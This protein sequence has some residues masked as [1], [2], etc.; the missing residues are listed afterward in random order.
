MQATRVAQQLE[1]V[2]GKVACRLTFYA[3]SLAVIALYWSGLAGPFILDDAYNLKPLEWWLRGGATSREVI[4]GN[5]SG[6]LGRPVSM[7]SFLLTVATGGMHPFP[8]KFGNLLIHIGCAAL[9]WQLARRLFTL[10]H[11]LNPHAEWLGLAVGVL[12]LLHPIHVSTVL[13]AVQRM[14]QLSTFFT[15]LA[16]LAYLAGRRSLEARNIGGA[17]RWL[18]LAFPMA[19]A[20]GMLSKENAAVAPALCLLV[21]L[22]YF[23]GALRSDR[24]LQAFFGVFL[25]VPV[26]LGMALLAGAPEK[27]LALYDTRDFTLAER[28]LSQPRA[29]MAYLGLLFWPRGG[30]MGVF[31]DDFHASTGVLQPAGTLLSILAL[32]GLTALAVAYRH[33]APSVFLGWLFFLVAHGVE[34]SFLPLE[35]Y[36]E[37]RNYLPAA[38]LVLAASGLAFLL[39]RSVR[40]RWRVP[41]TVF[42]VAS[43]AGVSLLAW[44]TSGQVHTWRSED[45]LATQAL[46]HRPASLRAKLLKT[47]IALRAA[48]FPEAKFWAMELAT[49][50]VKRHR[51][52]G[53]VHAMTIDCMAGTSANLQYLESAVAAAM[54][55]IQL[56]DASS[57]RPL[58]EALKNGNC[59]G[60][61]TPRLLADAITRIINKAQAQPD[62]SRPKWMLRTTAATLYARAGAWELA[63]RQAEIAWQPAVDPAVGALLVRIYVRLGDKALAEETL[64]EVA[65]RVRPY[66]VAGNQ[67]LAR[68]R[69]TVAALP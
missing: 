34:S 13:Y 38:G 39:A 28:L 68:L 58:A 45:A 31:V 4:F 46:E 12:W 30:L 6:E 33:R 36:F 1:S 3:A 20:L 22:A 63:R 23:R 15:L 49:G 35:L 17:R 7:A 54:N 10:D 40:Q 55:P 16:V 11:R 21:E 42:T 47:G 19:F 56:T 8:F 24:H 32:A 57:F 65:D 5:D 14:A 67:E 41:N 27:L 29:L 50:P 61:L 43:I 66:E 69:R 48:R 37:H 9:T 25:L 44:T 64:D 51:M 26:L 60:P 52:L 62:T 18:F 59:R 2:D 53:F